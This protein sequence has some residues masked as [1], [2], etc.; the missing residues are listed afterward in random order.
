ME[1]NI[2]FIL[3]DSSESQLCTK[4]PISVTDFFDKLAALTCM[5]EEADEG[6]AEALAQGA[7]TA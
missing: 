2:A 7:Y 6:N 4:K 1:R 3:Q 5:D